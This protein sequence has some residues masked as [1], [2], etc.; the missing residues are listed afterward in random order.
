MESDSSDSTPLEA[1][2]L[3]VQRTARFYTVGAPNPLVRDVWIVCHGFSQLA[4]TFAEPFQRLADDRRLIVAPEALSRFYLETRGAH[5]GASPVGATW[6]TREDREAEI[7]DNTA[8]LDRL[9]EHVVESLARHDVARDRI[10][11]HALGFSQGAV[12]VARWA[13]RGAAVIDHLVI[14]GHDIPIDVNVRA[15]GER[16][17]DLFISFVVGERDRL[18]SPE[19]VERTRGVLEASGVPFEIRTFDGG[20]V[21][22]GP[23]LREMMERA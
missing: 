2:H 13:A 18:V 19:V 8:Y 20:H 11:V 10:R 9:Y 14:W 7:A 16:L 4:G 12:A 1:Q 17:R 22:S 6:M 5:T 21:L 15:L 3:V 23:V